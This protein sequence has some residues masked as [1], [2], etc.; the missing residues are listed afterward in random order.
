M[1]QLSNIFVNDEPLSPPI[2][3]K[4]CEDFLNRFKGLMFNRDIPMDYGI[5]LAQKKESRLNSSIH[6]LGVFMDL[7]IIWINSMMIV[8]DTTIAKPWRPF[9]ISSRPALYTLEV[10]PARITEFQVDDKVSFNAI[11]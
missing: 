3:A 5:I 8:V 11:N 9:Y 1:N 2:Y 6:M 10:N 7:G 4:F